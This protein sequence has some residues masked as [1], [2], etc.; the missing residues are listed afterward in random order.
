MELVDWVTVFS[1]HFSFN[2]YVT[3]KFRRMKYNMIKRV[4]RRNEESVLYVKGDRV[5]MTFSTTIQPFPFR[6]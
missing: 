3:Y 4:S 5:E 6:T 2:N 1:V